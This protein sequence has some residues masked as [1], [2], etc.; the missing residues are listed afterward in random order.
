MDPLPPR[1]TPQREPA[2]L[3]YGLTPADLVRHR[4]NCERC[5]P[6]RAR[7]GRQLTDLPAKVTNAAIWPASTHPMSVKCP[8]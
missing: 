8:Q 1:F 4:R 7:A 5:V 2:S 6:L 3:V